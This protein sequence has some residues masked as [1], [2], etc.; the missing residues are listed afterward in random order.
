MD[1]LKANKTG[2]GDIEPINH[3]TIDRYLMHGGGEGNDVFK[4]FEGTP[5]NIVIPPKL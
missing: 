4:K 5:N 1:S 3:I 2:R